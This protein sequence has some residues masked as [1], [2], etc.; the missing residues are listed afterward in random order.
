MR[1]LWFGHNNPDLPSTGIHSLAYNGGG[2]LSSLERE[3][4]ESGEIQLTIAYLTDNA[5]AKKEKDGNVEYLPLCF[6]NAFG[7]KVKR[8]LTRGG[9]DTEILQL[10]MGAV[11]GVKPD[12]IHVFG[13]ENC[14]GLIAG[15]AKIP[16]CIHLQGLL[17]PYRNALYPPHFTKWEFLRYLGLSPWKIY[18]QAMQ[19]RFWDI[20]CQR[21]KEIFETC[22]NYLGRTDWDRRFMLLL[23]PTAHYIYCSEV[24]RPAFYEK[25]GAWKYKNGRKK[26]IIATTISAPF[27]KGYDFLLKTAQELKYTLHDDFEWRAFGLTKENG[28][29]VSHLININPDDV[30]VNTCGVVNQDELVAQLEDCDCY[31]HTS[32]IDNSPNSVCEAQLLGA[33]VVACYVGGIPSLIKHEET[34]VLVPAN[35]PYTAA[36]YIHQVFTDKAFAERLSSNG[37]AIATARHDRRSIVEQ[38]INAYKTIIN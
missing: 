20:R 38:V 3:I 36:S 17:I 31:V 34:G 22:N 4:K 6:N 27:Y 5:S 9:R 24:L 29:F 14:Y 8:R 32:Y 30:S 33:P 19:L 23:N 16:V 1:V 37:C 26:R 13:T 35:D 25:V 2:W 15:M 7:H 12:I 11:N 28:R 18:Q 21:E 10:F